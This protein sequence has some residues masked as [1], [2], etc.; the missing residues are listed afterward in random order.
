MG[1]LV[2]ENKTVTAPPRARE[3]TMK[4]IANRQSLLHALT[5]AAQ[6][7][8]T[9]LIKE[10]LAN[11]LITADPNHCTV[12]ATDMDVVAKRSFFAEV[13][14]PGSVLVP[15]NLLRA[16][17]KE[18]PDDSINLEVS[19]QILKVR[20]AS[21]KHDIATTAADEFPALPDPKWD[22][23][24]EISTKQFLAHLKAIVTQ[25]DTADA[26]LAY[27]CIRIEVGEGALSLF[28]LDG[29]AMG[30]ATLEVESAGS[31]IALLPKRS[32]R[33]FSA[34]DDEGQASVSISQNWMSATVAESK[35]MARLGEG[36]LPAP[37]NIPAL[38]KWAAGGFAADVIPSSIVS[39]IRRACVST[40]D[41]VNGPRAILA[42]A[43]GDLI[44][45]CTVGGT[46]SESRI[47]CASEGSFELYFN[48]QYILNAISGIS[49]LGDDPVRIEA[50]EA[51]LRISR[52]ALV[53]LVMA[54]EVKESV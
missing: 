34:I 33:L 30:F 53:F 19:K 31:A 23:T 21:I 6:A 20:G 5:L 9:R 29:N 42:A 7:V 28:A 12:Y 46:E 14:S 18:S 10:V 4:I 52:E 13:E 24:F 48:W 45:R 36:R 35:V 1:R 37:K 26:K 27:S 16:I 50:S 3:L 2:F 43:N 25:A 41:A 44:L 47:P 22:V 11:V 39:L 51:G 8:P 54:L 40:P 17:L 38:A 15:A 32:A 49:V